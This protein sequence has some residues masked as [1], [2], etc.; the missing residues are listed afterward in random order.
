M[1][2]TPKHM[3]GLKRLQLGADLNHESPLLKMSYKPRYA[4]DFELSEKWEKHEKHLLKNLIFFTQRCV[5]VVNFLIYFYSF[6]GD[7]QLFKGMID[8]IFNEFSGR[9]RAKH[10][11][12][13][14]FLKEIAF[15]EFRHLVLEGASSDGLN[16]TLDDISFYQDS[17]QE[18]T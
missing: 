15:K 16:V 3:T 18:S 7:N 5:D 8:G 4:L 1:K 6:E 11:L 14:K 10:Q 9:S 13:L 12:N 17:Q 2:T